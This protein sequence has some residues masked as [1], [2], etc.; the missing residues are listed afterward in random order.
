MKNYSSRKDVPDNYKWDLSF[1]YKDSVE[2]E[3]VYNST[4]KEIDKFSFYQ[5]RINNPDSLADFIKLDNKISCA[6]MDLYIYAMTYSDQDLSNGDALTMLSKADELENRYSVAISFFEPE[7]LSIDK[8]EYIKLISNEKLKGYDVLLNKI[9]RYKN[10]VL[11]KEEE[12]IVSSLTNTISS[13][14]QISSN[15][16]NSCNDY[17]FVT[18]EDK[19]KVEL[20][21]TNYRKIMKELPR[22]KRKKTY[23]QFN[24]VLKQYAPISAGLLNDYVKT[25]AVLAKLYKFNTAWERKLFGQELK[26]E[27]FISLM[28]T[29]KESKNIVAK[30]EKLKAKVLGINKLMPWDAP[31]ELYKVDK[32]YTIEDAQNMVREAVKP[33]GD[34]YV[35][36]YDAI[37]NERCVDYCQYKNKASGGYNVSS[38]DKKKSLI[39]MSFN[40]DLSSVSTLAHESGHNV[41]HQ[42]IYEN[43]DLVYRSQQIIVC[44]VASLVNECLLSNYLINNGTKEEALA[45]LSNI[46]GVILNNFTGAIQEGDME[47]KF[48]DYVENGGAI[49]KDYMCNLAENSLKDYYP[50]TK[51]DSEYEK[52]GW[53]RRSH[54]YDA[55]Y[56]FSYAVCISAALYVSG[57]ILNGNNDMLDKYK[58]FLSA[59]SNKTVEEVYS[60][61]G[62]NLNDKKVFEY[63]MSRL[64]YYIDTF[65]KLYKDVK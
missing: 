5:G 58:K 61:L 24:K 46:I 50:I 2:W 19:T 10:H 44:E 48:Y 40:D 30:Y 25:V 35:K 64:E 26:K 43:N 51:L 57:E 60:I 28:E 52:F 47:T 15:L 59:G 6:V 45:G 1:L 27:C 11:T 20:M 41:H 12:K 38:I 4:I 22:N 42:Y 16:L 56:L 34:D 32:K 14:G 23:E 33:L 55:F 65:A 21:T 54:Y 3:K 29:A 49:T 7:L 8:D 36:H 13:Y 53:V 39:F 18:L 63:A 17:G 9:Y 37:I 62:I 31:L